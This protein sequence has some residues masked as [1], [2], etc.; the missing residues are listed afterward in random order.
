MYW[1]FS[2]TKTKRGAGLLL[3]LLVKYI[4][5]NIVHFKYLIA[6]VRVYIQINLRTDTV[7]L[8]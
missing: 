6:G 4:D 2:L 3:R 1:Y 7:N 8:Y 5:K